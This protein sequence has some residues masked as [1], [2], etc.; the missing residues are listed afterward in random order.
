MYLITNRQIDK[1]KQGLKI[2]GDKPNAK[3]AHA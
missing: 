3:G 2:F 1:N